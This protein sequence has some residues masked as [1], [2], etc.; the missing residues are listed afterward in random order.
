VNVRDAVAYCVIE[1]EG[2]EVNDPDDHGGHTRF[3]LTFEVFLEERPGSTVADFQK[4][5][6]DDVIDILTERYALKPG[7]ARIADPELRLAVI[8]YGIHSHHRTSTKALQRSVGIH[9][10][11]LFGPQTED[12]VNRAPADVTRRRLLAERLKHFTRIFKADPS[13]RKYAGG[14]ITRVATLLAR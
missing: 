3:G 12:A 1:F 11:G 6:R 9:V 13:Q 7:F 10:D 14:W 5:T 2:G 4:L 8:D